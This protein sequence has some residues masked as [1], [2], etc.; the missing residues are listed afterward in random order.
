VP[1]SGHALVVEREDEFVFLAERFLEG[2][3]RAAGAA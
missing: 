1:G 3:R 2:A